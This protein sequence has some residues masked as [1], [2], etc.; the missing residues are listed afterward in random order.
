MALKSVESQNV[1]FKS[2]WRDEYLK[3]ISAFANTEGGV[4]ILGVDDNG[5]PSG[6]KD[7]KKLLEDMPNII[8]NKLGII[9]SV[10]IEKRKNKDVLCIQTSPSAVPISYDGRFYI[11]SGSTVQELKGQELANFI[12]RKMGKTWDEY[13]EERITLDDLDIETVKEFKRKAADRIPSVVAEDDTETLLK[14]LNLL[15]NGELKRAAVLLFGK[16]PQKFYPQAVVKIGKFLS[17]SE[18]L[19][20]DIIKGNLF[21]QMEDTLEILRSKYLISEISFEGIHRR[22][23]LEYPYEALREGIINALIHRDYLG[24]SHIQVRVYPDKLLIMN[25]GKLPPEIPVETLKTKHLSRPRNTL[26]AEVFYYAG[27]IEAWGSGTIK[28]VDN[29]VKQG[30]PEP[31]FHEEHGVMTVDFY[32][33]RFTEENLKKAGLNERQIKAVIYAKEKGKI[34]NR[35]YQEYCNT[36]DRTATRDLTDLVNKEILEQVGTTGKGTK[37]ILKTPQRRQ[38]RQKG[39]AK[40]PVKSKKGS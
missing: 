39:A 9:P 18:I 5:M 31:D 12:M 15:E 22:D 10:S 29:C 4:L 13:I 40:T 27:F 23:I 32:K 6:L 7:I 37:Y 33:D 14:K 1:E 21:E 36:S 35:E 19:T 8:R 30:L 20:T 24:T 3:V 25:E 16:S 34:T 17:E 28:I 38:S 11:K 2:N 26:L